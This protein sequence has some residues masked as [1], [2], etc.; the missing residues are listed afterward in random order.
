MEIKVIRKEFTDQST[1][2]DLLI[3]G[4]FFCYT[5][6]DMVREHGVKVAK[7]TAIPEGRY[8]VIVDQSVRFNRAMP[9]IL[10]VPMF[11]GIRIHNGNTSKHTDGCI[12]LGFTKNVNFVG[13]SRNAFNKF[14]DILYARLAK[15]QA[16]ITIERTT[17]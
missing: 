13:Q 11:D 1:I 2:G 7:Q 14:F 5:L 12:L 4:I 8:Q 6:E 15:E 17:T 9:H 3:D 10:N 16:F